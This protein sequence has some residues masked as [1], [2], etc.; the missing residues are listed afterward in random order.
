MDVILISIFSAIIIFITVYSMIKV[1]NIAY[2]REEIT[3]RKRRV[4]VTSS[5]LIGLLVTSILPFGYQK[6]FDGFLQPLL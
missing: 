6:I 4:L 3:P 2:K 1:L 5:I